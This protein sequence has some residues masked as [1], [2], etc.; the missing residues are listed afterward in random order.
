MRVLVSTT[1]G[2]GHFGPSLPFARAC[3]AAGHEVAVAAPKSFAAQ[4]DAAGLEHRPFD[5]APP[6]AL[7]RVFGEVPS[8][9]FDDANELVVRE[10]FGRLDAQAALPGLLET[11]DRWRPDVVLRDPVELGS[12]AAA[13]AAS[14]PHVQV[15]IGMATTASYVASHLESPLRELDALAG[16]QDGA[17]ARAMRSAPTLTTV[18]ALLDDAGPVDLPTAGVHR[19]RDTSPD[20][21]RGALPEP[22][23]SPSDP[24]VYVSFG[25]VAAG[26]AGFESVYAE[27]ASALADQPF[28]VL[29][30]TGEGVDP[31]ALA[32][33]PA[34]IH[35]ER[36]W[37]QAE[38]MPHCA[39]VLGHGGFGTTMAALAAGVPQVIAPLFSFDQRINAEHVAALGA[40]L[41]LEG[42]P[43]GL[44]AAPG[45]L[46]RLVREP[47]FGEAARSVAGTMATLPP[48]EDA[49]ALLEHLAHQ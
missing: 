37:P 24:L 5:D 28:R 1:A 38:V 32:P 31:V 30:T 3:V 21:S 2:A 16:L 47:S 27:I 18:P 29:L 43:A 44:V 49:V 41:H 40:G 9:S 6:E 26:V 17:A 42:G 11:I 12:L 33:L 8:M 36:W 15:A 10:V 48:V 20:S 34:N 45:A 39:A 4:V 25:S 35:V 13:E 46:R 7:G 19:F 22:W 14:I 23:G